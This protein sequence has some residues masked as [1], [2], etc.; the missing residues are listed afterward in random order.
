[1]V[2][3][4]Q[5]NAE[6]APFRRTI[7]VLRNTQEVKVEAQWEQW[8][9]LSNRQINRAFVPCYAIITLYAANPSSDAP[10]PRMVCPSA[11]DLA[12]ANPNAEFSQSRT[13][14]VS[15]P[16]DR[17]LS[18]ER[19]V[20]VE[21]QS[22]PEM[23]ESR[24]DTTRMHIDANSSQHGTRFMGLSKEHRQVL[25]RMHK[26][27]GHPSPQIMSQVLRNK[28]YPA[29]WSQG[30]LDMHCS[31]CQAQKR[32]YIARPA[33]LKYAMDFGDKV[34]VDGIT[35]T[36]QNGQTFHFYHYLDH[37]TNYHTAMIAPNRSE[38]AKGK[39][40]QGWLNWAGPPNELMFDSASEF[41]SE[42]FKDF[43]QS[44]SIKASTAPP[45]AHWQLGKCERHGMI[46]QEMLNKYE[47]DHAINSYPE[48]QEALSQCTS[49]KN[50]CSIRLGYAP[51]T[52][53]FGKGLRLPGSVSSDEEDAAHLMAMNG[54]GSGIV[55]RELL[56][57]RE[58]AR[59]AFHAADNNMAIR[60]AILRRDRPHRGY[61]APGEWVM[62]WR[63]TT[64]QG[65]WKG[66][67]KVIQQ[68][69][70]T[71]VFCIHHGTLVRAA[72]EHIRPVSALEAS[73]I[74]QSEQDILRAP[75]TVSIRPSIPE[76]GATQEQASTMHPNHTTPMPDGNTGNIIPTSVKTHL[77]LW[78]PHLTLWRP[79][80]DHHN[81]QHPI[82]PNNPTMNQKHHLWNPRMVSKYQCQAKTSMN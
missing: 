47:K 77:I 41:I 7:A 60:R 80:R 15:A 29:T 78:R 10:D 74:P 17:E 36:N 19:T 38:D 52:L 59:R 9:Y 37:G 5:S 33:T 21:E 68:E 69:G 72:P 43:T 34:S 30:V 14:D 81:H 75:D 66:P 13:P 64:G 39:F 24:H 49:A 58:A 25:I 54:S 16:T 23:T 45:Q 22:P 4:P 44:L 53:V 11:S 42:S 3:T 70:S 28:G 20:T 2:P 82:V 61:Y 71:S 40:I 55:F 35:W 65:S 73:V 63:E 26:N 56:A 67:A 18:S 76:N 32:P 48:L 62:Y 12:P 51:E 1:M 57:K 8:Q 46:L 27:L 79:H 6:E 31:V 50:S